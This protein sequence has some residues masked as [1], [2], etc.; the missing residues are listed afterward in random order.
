MNTA[1]S[2]SSNHLHLFLSHLFLQVQKLAEL[3]WSS[4]ML[5]V[6]TG[7][8]QTLH[9]CPTQGGVALCG[10]TWTLCSPMAT[11]DWRNSS[12]ALGPPLLSLG[13][14]PQPPNALSGPTHSLIFSCHSL[15]PKLG[16]SLLPEIMQTD[17][18]DIIMTFS[19]QKPL[20]LGPKAKTWKVF[21]II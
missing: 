7:N 16:Y 14:L 12:A 13:S 2:I 20:H 15:W 9:P 19:S 18:T 11:G 17:H 1:L 4:F 6:V 5:W 8:P 3:L 21:L 10:I